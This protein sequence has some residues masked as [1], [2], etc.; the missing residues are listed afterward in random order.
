ML[1]KSIRDVSVKGK[2]CFVR[3]D[4]NVPMEERNDKMYITDETRIHDVIPTVD[5]LLK[6]EAKIILCSHLGRPDGKPDPKQSLRPVCH[7]FSEITLH[8]IDFLNDCVGNRIRAKV[9][10]MKAGEI[11]MLENLRFHKEEEEND[12]VFA[13]QLADLAEVYVNDAFGTAHRAH[14]STSG[15]PNLLMTPCVAGFLMQRELEALG[16]ELRFPS[17]PFLVILG[18]AKVSDKIGVISALLQKANTILIGGAMSYTFAAAKGMRVGDS[19]YEPDKIDVARDILKQ[20]EERNVRVLLP[21]DHVVVQ[22]LDF[23]RRYA[24]ETKVVSGEIPD[25]WRGVDIGPETIEAYSQ[26]IADAMTILWNGPMGIFEI[27]ECSKGTFAIAR[28]IGENQEAKSIV[29][30]GDSITAVTKAGV[31]NKI[32]FVSTGGGATL[33]F[34][35]GKPLPGV[36]ALDD[37]Y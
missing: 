18:G 24:S 21:K 34:L 31:R 30:G 3:V 28:E 29:G 6:H 17:R 14:A 9:M 8:H 32:N 1:K 20:A 26:E 15:A 2:R 16:K 12:P 23:K 27:E 25:G 7:R 10:A 13:R 33:E 22:Q 19:M 36:V 35:E 11:V 4:F 5:Y 37:L